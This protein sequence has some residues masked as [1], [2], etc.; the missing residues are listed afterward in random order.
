MYNL[1]TFNQYS[2][3]NSSSDEV[4]VKHNGG[5]TPLL[6]AIKMSLFDSVVLLLR[7]KPGI[8]G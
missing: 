7:K 5:N 8:I 4:D 1:A 6:L 2:L 3:F